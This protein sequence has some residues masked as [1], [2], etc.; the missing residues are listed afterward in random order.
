M[1]IAKDVDEEG[2]DSL[3]H[4][5]AKWACTKTSKHSIPCFKEEEQTFMMLLMALMMRSNRMKTNHY[6]LSKLDKWTDHH[7]V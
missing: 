1:K 3:D 7:T 4:A 6:Q 5:W 2:N